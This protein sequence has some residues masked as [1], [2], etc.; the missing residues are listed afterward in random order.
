MLIFAPQ[1]VR[2]L[3]LFFDLN[4]FSHLPEVAKSDIA[5]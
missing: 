4:L 5:S 1:L 2:K 3:H